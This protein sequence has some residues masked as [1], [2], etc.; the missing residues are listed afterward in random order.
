MKL[1]LFLLC[2][3]FGLSCHE[4][5]GQAREKKVKP[6]KH[7]KMLTVVFNDTTLA[8]ANLF[9]DK[10]TSIKN[11]QKKSNWIFIG[12]AAAF[13]AGGAM[14]SEDLNSSAGSYNAA[15]YVGIGVMFVGVFGMAGSATFSGVQQL[16]L[17]PYTYKKFNRLI[18]M[19]KQGTRLPV[20]YEDKL[21]LYLTQR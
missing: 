16:R 19:Q 3:A 10:R 11:S 2:I 12:S 14:A 17:N 5:I 1:I 4:T 9:I 20:F 7:D 18:E 6:T 8:L 21:R 13:L 15:S